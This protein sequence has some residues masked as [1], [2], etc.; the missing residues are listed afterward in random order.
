MDSEQLQII[1][2]CEKRIA[3]AK[4]VL[5][6]AESFKSLVLDHLQETHNNIQRRL[7]I[8]NASS[9][10]PTEEEIRHGMHLLMKQDYNQDR[11][12]QDHHHP[13]A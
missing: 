9:E 5:A 4:Q 7:D 6:E 12:I 1:I 8:L 13:D 10:E 2:D 3:K 11:F